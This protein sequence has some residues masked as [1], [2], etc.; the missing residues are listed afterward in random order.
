MIQNGIAS[1]MHHFLSFRRGTACVLH[2]FLCKTHPESS[3]CRPGAH[4]G[5]ASFPRQ[6][7]PSASRPAIPLV[8]IA[9]MGY[10]ALIHVYLSTQPGAGSIP[11]S[12]RPRVEG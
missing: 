3:L 6:A 1:V 7:F 2:T 5:P 9:D 11:A 10:S 8:A 4:P 12:V